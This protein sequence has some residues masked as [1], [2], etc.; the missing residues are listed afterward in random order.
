M[1]AYWLIIGPASLLSMAGVVALARRLSY[2]PGHAADRLA[3][4][5]PV[6]LP[7]RLDTIPV[8]QTAGRPPWEAEDTRPRR[9]IVRHDTGGWSSG[10]CYPV[11]GLPPDGD[12]LDRMIHDARAAGPRPRGMTEPQEQ[13]QEQPPV[14][15]GPES[16]RPDPGQLSEYQP[17]QD[18]SADAECAAPSPRLANQLAA[19]RAWAEWQQQ[20][21][22]ILA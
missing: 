15:Y 16:Y 5:E 18:S 12:W 1:S 19:V 7:A 11:D 3:R 8:A 14:R 20:K 9:E 4:S 10:P 22:V 17:G 21:A 13:E 2:R 6:T